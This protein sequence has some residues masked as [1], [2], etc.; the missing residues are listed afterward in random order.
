MQSRGK[1][2]A[3]ALFDSSV[4][5]TGWKLILSQNIGK[6]LNVVV[7]G[8]P[9]VIGANGQYSVHVHVCH[10]WTFYSVKIYIQDIDQTY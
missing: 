10:V 6:L 5:K 4:H 2:F 7:E 9:R 1:D 8:I 3:K